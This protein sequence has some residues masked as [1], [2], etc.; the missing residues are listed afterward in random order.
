M[1]MQCVIKS[2]P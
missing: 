2:R 1:A